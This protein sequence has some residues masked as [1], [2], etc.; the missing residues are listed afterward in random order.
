M[1]IIIIIEGTLLI[2]EKEYDSYHLEESEVVR[3]RFKRKLAGY[4]EGRE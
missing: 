4:I 2:T 3:T 1:I